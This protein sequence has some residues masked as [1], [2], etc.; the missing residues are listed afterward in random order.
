MSCSKSRSRS[1]RICHKLVGRISPL[2]SDLAEIVDVELSAVAHP[3][4][5]YLLIAHSVS[6]HED[7]VLDLLALR[8]YNRY[9]F[10]GL[11]HGVLVVFSE[12]VLGILRPVSVENLGIRNICESQEKSC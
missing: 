12:V 6:D 7:D 3:A 5:T 4:G 11:E 10:I 8:F 2:D 1:G 9:G